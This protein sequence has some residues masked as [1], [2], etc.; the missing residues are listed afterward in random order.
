VFDEALSVDGEK[1]HSLNGLWRHGCIEIARV[2]E[3]PIPEDLIAVVRHELQISDPEDGW[4]SQDG[5]D[6]ALLAG[7]GEVSWLRALVSV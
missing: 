7:E 6:I 3:F 2:C 5:V 1:V 4:L